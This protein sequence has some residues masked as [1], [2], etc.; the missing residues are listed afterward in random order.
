MAKKP[1]SK[2][3]LFNEAKV[4]QVADEIRCV[5]PYFDQS[6]FTRSIVQKFPQLELKERI[7]WIS[8]NL[9]ACLPAGYQEATSILLAS[10]PPPNDNT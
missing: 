10:L 9:K 3:L 4:K 2:D 1:L 6:D 8:E 5:Y 7:A